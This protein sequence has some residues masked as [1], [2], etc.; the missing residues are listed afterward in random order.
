[1][2]TIVLWAVITL[3]GVSRMSTADNQNHPYGVSFE[4]QRILWYMYVPKYNSREMDTSES[5]QF[6]CEYWTCNATAK[7]LTIRRVTVC[8]RYGSVAWYRGNKF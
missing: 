7:A 3:G 5:F 4:M 1:M 6:P 2:K 8:P